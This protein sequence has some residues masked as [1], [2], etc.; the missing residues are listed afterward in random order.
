RLDPTP[1]APRPRRAPG[2]RSPLRSSLGLPWCL[3]AIG[4]AGA[5]LVEGDPDA[6]LDGAERHLH[7]GGDLGL[8]VAAVVGELDG[9]A[10]LGGKL[11]ERL[12]NLLAAQLEGDGNPGVGG[13]RRSLIPPHPLLPP[14]APSS[15]P[16]PG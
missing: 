5:Q 10:L 1:R 8:R 14:P 15:A 9:L 7:R 2:G 11:G 6:P 12:A 16:S 13:P 4:E 3:Q